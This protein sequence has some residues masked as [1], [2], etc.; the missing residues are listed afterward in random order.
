[1]VGRAGIAPASLRLKAGLCLAELATHDWC[2]T[3]ELHDPPP[4]Y[5][6]GAP[7]SELEGHVWCR[8][9]DLHQLPAAY[10]AAAHLDVLQRQTGRDVATLYAF[11]RGLAVP[12]IPF[13]LLRV[14]RTL[15]SN[16]RRVSAEIPS[17]SRY[18]TREWSRATAIQIRS[19]V[20]EFPRATGVGCLVERFLDEP[21]V[22]KHYG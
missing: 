19:L 14:S 12:G 2:P 17:A 4:A 15:A 3:I 16:L 7:L 1:M 22:P 6:T 11:D 9:L 8:W 20:P 13:G 5:E 10:Q 21:K 18:G